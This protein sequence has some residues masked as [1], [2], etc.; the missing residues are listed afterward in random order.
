MAYS[1][2]TSVIRVVDSLHPIT[3]CVGASPTSNSLSVSLVSGLLALH[4]EK[5]VVGGNLLYRRVVP[6]FF[7]LVGSNKT[8][9]RKYLHI[10]TLYGLRYLP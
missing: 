7:D 5:P 10:S 9:P 1:V 3:L 4:S 2:C 8:Q 6:L